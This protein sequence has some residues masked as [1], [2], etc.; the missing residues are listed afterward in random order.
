MNGS[1][2]TNRIVIPK[3][4]MNNVQ[5]KFLK[6]SSEMPKKRHIKNL[7]QD[8]KNLKNYQMYIGAKAIPSKS[9]K[10]ARH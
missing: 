10:I 5:D 6:I 1:Q 2:N 8:A 7:T 4:T 3:L 9:I